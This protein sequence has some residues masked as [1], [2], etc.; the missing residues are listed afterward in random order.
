MQPP[1]IF[2]I[3]IYR[4]VKSV[5]DET[6]GQRSEARAEEKLVGPAGAVSARTD[7]S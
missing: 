5:C 2:Q 6:L 1:R 7:A 4:Y 3:T